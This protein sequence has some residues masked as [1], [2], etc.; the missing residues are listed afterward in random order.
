MARVEVLLFTSSTCPHCPAAE[1]VAERVCPG[2]EG[3]KYR[4]IRIKTQ[5]GKE[6]SAVY[7]IRGTPTFIIRDE[8]HSKIERIVGVPSDD[9]LRGKIE[10]V[11]GIKKGFF[12]RFFS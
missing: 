6:L 10:K 5:E 7:N 8:S 4:K 12:S 1:K 9:N 2:I 3:V 11:M